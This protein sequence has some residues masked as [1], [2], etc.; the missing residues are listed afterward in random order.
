MSKVVD[1]AVVWLE[2][3]GWGARGLRDKVHLFVLKMYL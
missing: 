1:G 2:R 3:L